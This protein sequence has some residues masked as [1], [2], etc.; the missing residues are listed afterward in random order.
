MNLGDLVRVYEG[1]WFC[2][3]RIKAICGDRVTVDFVDWIQE[4]ADHELR[5]EY[6]FFKRVLTANPLA[7]VIVED[8]RDQE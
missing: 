4:Y 5:V 8:Y 3:G 7:G 6:I 2:E 1:E